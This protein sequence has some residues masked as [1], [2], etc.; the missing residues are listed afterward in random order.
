VQYKTDTT[1]PS[2]SRLS[3]GRSNLAAA[4]RGY[5][6]QDAI[7]AYFM[8]RVVAEQDGSL[9][10]N[11]PAHSGDNFDDVA[12]LDHRGHVR[13]QAKDSGDANRFF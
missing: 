10:A 11:R 2:T 9:T 12:T 13:R 7:V 3:V 4:Q 1:T 5:T 6:Y 8:T